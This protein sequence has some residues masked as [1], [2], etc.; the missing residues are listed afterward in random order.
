MSKP[1]DHVRLELW[2]IAN[3]GSEEVSADSSLTILQEQGEEGKHDTILEIINRNKIVDTKI[4]TANQEN[5]LFGCQKLKHDKSNL[6]L[7][8]FYKLSNECSS[9]N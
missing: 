4:F 1:E 8:K 7:F 6:C 3:V 9:N 2:K 5:L